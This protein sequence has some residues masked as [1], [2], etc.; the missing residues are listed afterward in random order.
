MRRNGSDGIRK[1]STAYARECMGKIKV[2]LEFLSVDNDYQCIMVS[3]SVAGEG[4]STIT[5][6]L[7]VSHAASQKKTLLL[8]ADLRR[9]T[10]H[11]HFDLVNGEG[12]SDII[13]SG[14]D[15]RKFVVKTTIPYLHIITA[16][17]IPPNPAE[18]LGS[19]RMSEMIREMKNE[20]DFILVDTSPILLV[21][22]PVSM[23]KH[24]DG[25]ILVARY[26]Y[27]TIPNL[28][29]TK[30]Q[31][32]LVGKPVIGAILNKTV[33]AKN[34]YGYGYQEYLCGSHS[35]SRICKPQAAPARQAGK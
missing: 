31:L 10:Q 20:Y 5:A 29:N 30:Q 13:L 32:Q 1:I 8:D 33:Q 26:N 7:A 4:K 27:T 15:W 3:S 28:V 34:Q 25:I 23:S 9:P 12:L 18:L 17:R 24:V 14:C 6:N 19:R 11:R 2:N 16:G 21:P 22:D 35:N